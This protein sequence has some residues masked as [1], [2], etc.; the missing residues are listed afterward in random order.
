MPG[1]LVPCTVGSKITFWLGS[2]WYRLEQWWFLNM[3][4]AVSCFHVY[5]GSCET[6]WPASLRA[7]A[8]LK[9]VGISSFVL[10]TD[11]ALFS[12]RLSDFT[13]SPCCISMRS[14]ECGRDIDAWV[15]ARDGN[16]SNTSNDTFFRRS[17]DTPQYDLII[18]ILCTSFIYFYRSF[19]C[20]C[21][22]YCSLFITLLSWVYSG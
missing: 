5:A 16:D 19:L 13:L 10:S 15:W 3:F 22:H 6:A 14:G 12:F 17:D 7:T 11:C 1:S 4:L 8:Q 9:G 18:T 21:S 20:L 2:C